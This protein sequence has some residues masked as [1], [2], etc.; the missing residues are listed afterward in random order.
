MLLYLVLSTLL[1]PRL[2]AAGQQHMQEVLK[3]GTSCLQTWGTEVQQMAACLVWLARRGGVQLQSAP[4]E[5]GTQVGPSS[6]LA[7]QTGRIGCTP[8]FE[9]T[10]CPSA[11][12]L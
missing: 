10:Y 8:T 4:W 5:E 12:S 7:R 3:L 11:C 2:L 9:L 1:E 6:P